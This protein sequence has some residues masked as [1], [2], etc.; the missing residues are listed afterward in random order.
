MFRTAPI[1]A[2]SEHFC[3]SL[4]MTS[5]KIMQR[6]A[7]THTLKFISQKIV[8]E[9]LYFPIWW[10]STGLLKAARGWMTN[11]KNLN[12]RLGMWI[13]IKH[14]FVPMY[15]EY[16]F[17]GRIISFFMRLIILVFRSIIFIVFFIIY[18]LIFVLYVISLP[19]VIFLIFYTF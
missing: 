5:F 11:M 1:G 7:T 3:R 8:G 10:Y 18:S 13:W 4:R 19:A 15:A 9:F 2:S 14:I 16:N 6:T 12:K 17:W